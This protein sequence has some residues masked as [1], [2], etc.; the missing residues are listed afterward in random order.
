MIDTHCH[1]YLDQFNEDRGELI[2]TI[3]NKGI[4]AV[5]IP[6]IDVLSSQRSIDLSLQYRGLLFTA[7]GIHPNYA[8]NADPKGIYQLINNHEDVIVALGEIGLDYYRDYSSPKEQQKVFEVMLAYAN[9]FDLPICLHNREATAPLLATLDQWYTH[10]RL[11]QPGGVFHAYDGSEN[12]AEWGIEHGFYF[13]IGG[14]I[15]YQKY[16]G[17]QNIIR[18]IGI[19]NIVLETDAPYLTPVPLRGKRNSP[20]HLNII[21]QKIAQ[22]LNISR[23]KVIEI[24]DQNANRLFGFKRKMPN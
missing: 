23:D 9:E 5:L 20:L 2:R 10:D 18:E 24:T 7:V 8:G 21:S 1:F 22:L 19:N 3:R 14:L 16:K 12:V 13:G 6:G 17:L 11:S 15:T 4:E